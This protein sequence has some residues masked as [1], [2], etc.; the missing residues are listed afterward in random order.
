MIASRGS[1]KLGRDQPNRLQ[2][3]EPITVL[4]L[5]QLALEVLQLYS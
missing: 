4:L 1:T 5:I 3:V 2:L